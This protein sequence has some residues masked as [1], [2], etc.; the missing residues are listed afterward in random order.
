VVVLGERPTLATAV[1]F[2]CV[3]AGFVLIKRVAIREQ[4]DR[5]GIE[6]G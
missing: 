1:G 3:C 5:A 4:L 2:C 6:F